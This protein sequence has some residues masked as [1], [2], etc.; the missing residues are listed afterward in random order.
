M[1][2]DNVS[3]MS[4]Q[5]SSEPTDGLLG[6]GSSGLIDNG[7]H[8]WLLSSDSS[9]RRKFGVHLHSGREVAVPRL[10]TIESRVR[11][12]GSRSHAVGQEL[13]ARAGVCRNGKSH[14]GSIRSRSTEQYRV[15]HC[16]MRMSRT[17]SIR[18]C[19]TCPV[20]DGAIVSVDP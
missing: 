12:S 4:L 7:P 2:T 1:F 15:W 11:C 8:I 5:C 18:R 13:A 17:L 6:R 14:E 10:S 19:R 9:R 3:V 20:A 16:G